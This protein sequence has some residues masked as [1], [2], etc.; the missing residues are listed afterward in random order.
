MGSSFGYSFSFFRQIENR[1]HC[2]ERFYFASVSEAG[3]GSYGSVRRGGGLRFETV[4]LEGREIT[5]H[6]GEMGE[7][8]ETST[9]SEKETHENNCREATTETD[10]RTLTHETSW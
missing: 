8:G 3:S 4:F 1:W 5:C 2:C 6:V 9:D 7:V 10:V